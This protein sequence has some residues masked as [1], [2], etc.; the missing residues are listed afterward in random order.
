MLLIKP[1]LIANLQTGG[2]DEVKTALGQALM[3]EHATIPPYLY[4]LYSLDPA[5]NGEIADLIQSVVVEEMLHMTLVCNILN[6][7]GGTPVLDQPSVIPTYPGPLPGG[8]EDQLTV[9][10]TPFTIDLVH[11]VFMVIEEPENPLNFP[12]LAAIVEP[13]Q[14]I[15][16]FYEAIKEKIGD[17][18]DSYFSSTPRNQV[19][20]DLMDEAVIVTSVATAVQAIETIVEQ[21]EGTKASPAEVVGGDF[22]HYYRFAEVYHGK[23]LIKNPDCNPATPPDKRYVYGGAS[24][25]FDAT[26]VYPVP[27]NPTVSLY[28]DGSAAR[29]AFDTFNYT[30][31]NLL[32]TLHLVFNGQP[33][34]LDAAIGLMFS[35]KQQ[36]KDMM[37]GIGTN[38]TNVGPSFT[39]Q[40]VNP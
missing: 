16:Q 34:R 1:E 18:G 12:V 40:P 27:A 38:G 2:L 33:D 32:G 21:G 9:G 31:T 35:L 30:Y 10:L 6:A 37:S 24:I 19:G 39:Y 3:L 36:A 7:L 20:P 13:P 29:R 26:G 5:R 17:L 25:P 22:A 28:P 4:A 15:G 23:R 8:V 14:T 11:N